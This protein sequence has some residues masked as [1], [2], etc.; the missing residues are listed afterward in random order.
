[1]SILL[2]SSH[3]ALPVPTIFSYLVVWNSLT[4]NNQYS[5]NYHMNLKNSI[6]SLCFLR[7]VMRQGPILQHLASSRLSRIQLG[8]FALHWERSPLYEP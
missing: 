7:S 3:L 5:Q 6:G 8:Q 2:K 1:M 4:N